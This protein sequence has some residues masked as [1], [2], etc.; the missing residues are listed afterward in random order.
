MT[1]DRRIYVKKHI[2][3]FV[4]TLIIFSIGIAIGLKISDARISLI[5]NTARLQQ[6]QFESIQLQYAFLNAAENTTC[7]AF[8]TTLDQ[9]VYDL[10]NARLKLESYLEEDAGEEEFLI[11]KREYMVTELRYWLLA[12]QAKKI[13]GE[14]TVSILFFY[15]RNVLCDTCSTQGI[16]LTY[17]KERFKD[18]LLVFSLD[19]DADEPM[20][21]ILKSTYNITQAPSVVVEEKRFHGLTKKEELEEEIC[22]RYTTQVEECKKEN[23][24]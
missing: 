2:A 5:T 23:G 3:A 6:A 17:L 20:I 15:R 21:K 4:I 24:E 22:R 18:K 10:E 7:A 9:N 12:K 19:V 1:V 14:D 16:I 13:C 8:R 11:A